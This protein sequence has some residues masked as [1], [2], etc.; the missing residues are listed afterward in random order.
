M[1]AV[2]EDIRLLDLSD[3][4]EALRLLALQQASYLSEA[5]VI[6]FSDIP[7]LRDTLSSLRESPE[8]FYGCFRDGELIACIAYEQE[9]DILTICRMMVHPGSFR[10]GIAAALLGFVERQASGV[11]EFH[12]SAVTT[13][14]PAVRLYEKHGFKPTDLWEIAPG[15]QMAD[16]VKIVSD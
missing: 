9:R 8:S 13:N 7:P 1:S 14:E 11:R 5:Q 16:Y 15:I 3:Q 4:T 12:V 2:S 6:G 10:Q